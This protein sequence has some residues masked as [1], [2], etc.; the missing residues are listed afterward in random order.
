MTKDE[1]RVRVISE[2]EKRTQAVLLLWIPVPPCQLFSPLLTWS[3]QAELSLLY[4]HSSRSSNTRSW[5]HLVPS[6]NLTPTPPVASL[7]KIKTKAAKMLSASQNGNR[8]RLLNTLSVLQQ[9]IIFPRDFHPYYYARLSLSMRGREGVSLGTV[10]MAKLLAV[11][12]PL[13]TYRMEKKK[14]RCLSSACSRAMDPQSH[15]QPGST[16]S[17]T[18]EGTSVNSVL[19][20]TQMSDI[21]AMLCWTQNASLQRVQLETSVLP[22]GQPNTTVHR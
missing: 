6:N 12:S 20:F 2:Q 18:Q 9:K 5:R 3:L 8:L 19:S 10:T 11:S 4:S 22:K 21:S 17:K 15:E 13:S 7:V 16:W 1:H 14:S